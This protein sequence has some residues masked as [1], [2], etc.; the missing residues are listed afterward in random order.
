LYVD[1]SGWIDL[2]IARAPDL[3]KAGVTAIGFDGCTASLEPA[4]PTFS[5][6]KPGTSVDDSY[7]DP[8]HDPATYGGGVVPGYAI[9]KFDE[10]GG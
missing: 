8:L 5:D 6:D 10:H 1:A 4:A 9:T 3:R 2:V 7:L